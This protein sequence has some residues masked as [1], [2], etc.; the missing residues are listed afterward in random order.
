MPQN[1]ALGDSTSSDGVSAE[2]LNDVSVNKD[3]NLSK[4]MSCMANYA[5]FQNAC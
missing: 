1:K 2:A 5:A 3:I 4:A